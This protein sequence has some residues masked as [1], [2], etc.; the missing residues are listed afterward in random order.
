MPRSLTG[1][2]PAIEVDIIKPEDQIIELTGFKL[3]F[4]CRTKPAGHEKDVVWLLE[5]EQFADETQGR[6]KKFVTTFRETGVKQIIARIG[7]KVP[8][9]RKSDGG[10]EVQRPP[11]KL[12]GDQDDVI[13]YVYKT[14]NKAGRLRD[15]LDSEPTLPKHVR[16][17]TRSPKRGGGV[18][19]W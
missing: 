8:H 1:S 5:G 2:T 18:M 12:F 14:A 10:R 11:K 4:T 7:A 15:I 6:G 19:S 3:T 9:G 16:G 13:L 17:F